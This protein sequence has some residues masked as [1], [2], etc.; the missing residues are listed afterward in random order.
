MYRRIELAAALM[1]LSLV[2]FGA[3]AQ[4]DAHR[5]APASL[6]GPGRGVLPESSA[7]AYSQYL[8]PKVNGV[9]TVYY[10]ID[11]ASDPNATA[12]IQTAIA[13]FNKDFAKIIQWVPWVSSSGPNYVDI[14]LSAGDTSGEYEANEGYEAI[15]AQPM[16]GSTDCTIGTILHEMGHVIGLWH[17]Q[18]RPDRD[19][20]VTVNYDNVIKGS[21]SN[22]QIDTDNQ[23]ILAGYDYASVMQY[24]PFAFSRD[25]GPV[26]ESIPAGIPLSGYEGVP[27]YAGAPGTAALPKFD[28]SAGDKETIMRLYGAAPTEVTV[29][30]NPIGLQVIVDGA[31]VTTPQLYKWSLNSSHT[32]NLPDGVQTLPG[33]ILN[34][35]PAVA[36]TFYY[37]YGRW[38]DS[39]AASHTIKVTA[40]NGSGVFPSTAPAVATY[41]AN[42]IELVPYTAAVYPANTGQ[43][44]VSPLPGD[45]AEAPGSFFV[46]RQQATLTATPA[47]G[48]NFYE[49]N[50]GPFWLPGGLGSNPKTFY[51]PD[52]GNPVDPTAEFSDT[53]VYTLDVQPESF[54]SNLYAYIDSEFFYTPKNFSSY[55]DSTWT[56]TSTHT[57]S[58]DAAEQPYSVNSRYNFAG[59][60]DGGAIA[61]RIS[62][63]PATATRYVATVTP[64][65]QPATNFDYP[66]CGGS[67][68]ISPASPTD[69]G[70]YPTGRALSF[71][72]TPDA[73]WV[74]AGWTY[75][76]TGIANPAGLTA[77]DE[78]LVF[79]NFNTVDVPL[80][81][82]SI[83]PSTAIARGPAFTLTLSGTGFTPASLVSANGQYRAVTYVN[84]TTLSVPMTAAD[85]AATGAFQVFVEN[86]PTGSN[87]C[88]VFGETTFLVTGGVPPATIPVFSPVAGTYKTAESV[89]ITDANAGATI[90]YTINGGTP[91]T[92]STL[93]TGPVSVAESETLKAIALATG[94][95]QSGVG[96][97]KY[98][99]EQPA[100][101]PVFS[102]AAGTYKAIES[103]TITDASAGATIYYTTNGSTPTTASSKYT[104]PISVGSSE[105]LKAIAVATGD[106]TSA[107]G[108]AKYTIELPAATPKFSPAAG[109]Y[110]TVQKVKIT[111]AT[112]GAVIYYTT[113]GTTPTTASTVYTG[114]IS[115]SHG[116]TLEAIALATGGSESKVASA[117]YTID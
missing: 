1:S 117:T 36:A 18:S 99:I 19:T 44:T 6:P 57:L 113:N 12:K 55:Y 52:T 47:S 75:D 13:T 85:I 72:A 40:G 94:Y 106:L 58:V 69:D 112:A 14:N 82:T 35:N 42:F 80:T 76:I 87:G 95:S 66:P 46:A 22:F 39:T 70:F 84:S 64:E 25:G 104:G 91:T 73:G 5:A 100:A 110:D 59:W 71:S 9:A 20:Y 77:T 86:F 41:S 115:V 61:H 60:S 79:A 97:A 23:Q 7:I 102:P 107:V 2:A 90:Y 30:S 32:L 31:T 114:S 65:F 62:S 38:S 48:W 103:V 49:F 96:S 43:V 83:S 109:T 105:T 29:T 92:A 26:I 88:A 116:E 53:P 10:L 111:D 67:A 98:T 28:Y 45:Y 68:S 27:A 15:P 33:Y 4:P 17:E 63:L 56:A 54:S 34:S 51:V 101:T 3:L 78:T 50:N 74:F 11:S 81:L 24:I 21:W 16:A 37:T 8:W 89:T 93:Y 108:S